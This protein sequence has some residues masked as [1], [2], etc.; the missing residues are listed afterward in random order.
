MD[1]VR[2]G[3]IG[4]GN[5][6]RSH[7][8]QL[9]RFADVAMIAHSDVVMPA[10]KAAA[11][12]YGGRAYDDYLKMIE[13]EKL[14]AV[15]IALPPHLHGT[16]EADCAE[17]GLHMLVE[18]PVNL[19]LE[20]A[21]RAAA[22]IGKAGVIAS[23]G[24]N[25]RHVKAGHQVRELLRGKPIATAHAVRWF[26]L[27]PKAW[28]KRYDQGGGQLVE[29]GT[30][31]VDFL[32]FVLGEVKTVQ[33][34]YGY[35]LLG[36]E[37]ET[38]IPDTQTVTLEFESGA[39]ATLHLFCLM[40]GLQR[41]GVEFWGRSLCVKF[42]GTDLAIESPE[43]LAV[44]ELESPLFLDNARASVD[45]RFV[46][47]VKTGDRALLSSDFADAVKSAEVCLAANRSAERGGEPVNLP[48]A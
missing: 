27:P 19:Y 44:P 26:K 18:K 40:E 37:P 30:H 5:I 28:W 43:P 16:I 3:F 46:E 31:E 21:R 23:V 22:A 33:A 17:R 41:G 24:Y 32:R 11:Q 42:D 45:R 20:P 34:R 35:T 47:A 48:L 2:M 14:D 6:S 38:T 25:Y 1:K 7:K 39:L 4:S 13:T 15:L 12:A 10:A 8:E 29:Q 9:K 36:K